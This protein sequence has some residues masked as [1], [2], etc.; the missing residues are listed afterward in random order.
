M[1]SSI[2]SWT[3]TGYDHDAVHRFKDE[4]FF[5][6]GRNIAEARFWKLKI[7][8]MDRRGTSSSIT[9][10]KEAE[11]DRGSSEDKELGGENEETAIGDKDTKDD[12]K[13]TYTVDDDP[14]QDCHYTYPD[15]RDRSLSIVSVMSKGYRYG[16]SKDYQ[17][18]YN[19]ETVIEENKEEEGKSV[20][21]EKT[22]E[23]EKELKTN[24]NVSKGIKSTDAVVNHHLMDHVS[25]RFY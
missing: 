21:D 20:K 11:N 4:A 17:Y 19:K 9:F 15:P 24:E 25:S 10:D 7:H 12:S 22:M 6:T 5:Q 16:P 13:Y 18:G 1:G 8:E 23:P 3:W 2:M 14:P